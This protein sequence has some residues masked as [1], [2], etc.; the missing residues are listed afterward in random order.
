MAFEYLNAHGNAFLRELETEGIYP[1]PYNFVDKSDVNLNEF[2]IHDSTLREGE[3]TPGVSF[4]LEDKLMIASRLSEAGIKRLES[5]FPAASEKQRQSI[6]ALT[7]LNLDSEIVAFARATKGDVKAAA[8]TGA[9]G[10]IV[11]F[12][13]SRFHREKKFHGMNQEDYLTKLWDIIS[14][15]ESLGL[16]VI[17]SGEDTSREGD[18]RF[19]KR[20]YKTAENAG[21]D[22]ARVIDTLGCISPRG[23]AFLI[24]VI[25]TTI[26]IPIEVHFHNDMGLALANSITALEA[27]A[28][29]ISTCVNGLGERA[30][31]TATEEAIAA[32]KILFR[33]NYFKIERLT[34]LSRFVEQITD[35]SMAPNKPITGLSICT[36]TSGIH[37]HGV[38]SDP[39][40]YEFYPPDTFGGR[41]CVELN[42]LSGRHGVI[43]LAK[44]K[45]GLNISENTARNVL[46]RIKSSYSNEGRQKPYTD[47]ELMVLIQSFKEA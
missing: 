37:Q 3:Q 26:G 41:R 6:E 40:T 13:I 14:Y 23:V 39:K 35:V 12:S 28:S 43:Y 36:H 20:A 24:G 7:N 31:I 29:T 47:K 22:R 5:G 2:V 32:L 18:L 4:T 44:N 11:C 45:L 19:L 10:V 25:R 33:V 1:S 27:G 9:N 46:A 38:F 34:E 15:A 17:Y 21:A 30:G 16:L 8:D 42:E